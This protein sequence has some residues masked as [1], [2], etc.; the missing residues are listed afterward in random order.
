MPHAASTP[1]ISELNAARRQRVPMAEGVAAPSVKYS[2]VC[3]RISRQ[4]Q[5]EC[6]LRR[7]QIRNAFR[8]T[9][10]LLSQR[11]LKLT[12]WEHSSRALPRRSTGESAPAEPA[13]GGGVRPDGPR[14]H[15]MSTMRPD[16]VELFRTMALTRERIVVF[17]KS[18]FFDQIHA[19][20]VERVGAIFEALDVEALE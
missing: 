10:N 8:R 20:T 9:S 7:M 2:R 5:Y 13:R 17:A 16:H 15:S 6:L 14:R 3:S 19:G 1:D 4:L 18:R 12:N 11:R